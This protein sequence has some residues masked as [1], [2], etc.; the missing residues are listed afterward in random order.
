MKTLRNIKNYL[1]SSNRKNLILTILILFLFSC[2]GENKN[3]EEYNWDYI[4]IISDNSRRYL[5]DKYSNEYEITNLIDSTK[6]NYIISK[7]EKDSGN[8]PPF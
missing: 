7:N 5:F 1:V 6:T 4:Y 8:L 2:K 3:I